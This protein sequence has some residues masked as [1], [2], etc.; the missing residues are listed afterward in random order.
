MYGEIR[1]GLTSAVSLSIVTINSIY[2][3]TIIMA[4]LIAICGVANAQAVPDEVKTVR[5]IT[6]SY[7]SPAAVGGG[8]C[9]VSIRNMGN[10]TTPVTIECDG[11]IVVVDQVAQYELAFALPISRHIKIRCGN[12]VIVFRGS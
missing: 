6:A 12:T 3:K 4:I 7:Y 1:D 10:T 9:M 11:V 2:M 5:D 8:I